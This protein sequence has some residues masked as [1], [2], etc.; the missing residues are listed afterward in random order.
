MN[1]NSHQ[2]FISF[3]M[4]IEKHWHFVTDLNSRVVKPVIGITIN[5][6]NFHFVDIHTEK[7]KLIFH[8]PQSSCNLFM[9]RLVFSFQGILIIGSMTG[10]FNI[11]LLNKAI[12]TEFGEF[13]LDP[14]SCFLFSVSIY[15]QSSSLTQV[16]A[17]KGNYN[18]NIHQ[19]HC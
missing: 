11:Q 4:P 16:S 10:I 13:F 12:E 14:L 3:L 17:F 19:I 9:K 5:K 15:T 2:N 7:L 1:F 6:D 8:L 18:K